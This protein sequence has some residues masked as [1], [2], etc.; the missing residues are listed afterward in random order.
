M[1]RVWHRYFPPTNSAERCIQ[2]EER[3]LGNA[4][5]DLSRERAAPPSLIDKHNAAS[6]CDRGDDRLRVERAQHAK[7]Y[8]LSGNSLIRQHLGRSE[9]FEQAVAVRDQ[10]EVIAVAPT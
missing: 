1:R 2:L 5:A 8:H 7:V 10:S 4:H 3:L 6:L 9:C